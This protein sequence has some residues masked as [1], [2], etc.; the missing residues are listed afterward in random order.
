MRAA[1]VVLM[2]GLGA[3][4]KAPS[5]LSVGSTICL[6]RGARARSFLPTW[7]KSRPSADISTLLRIGPNDCEHRD[8]FCI[9]TNAGPSLRVAGSPTSKW[10]CLS[11][12][13]KGLAPLQV[14]CARPSQK[15]R[16]LNTASTTLGVLR[17]VT[18]R[19]LITWPGLSGSGK[20]NTG[21]G[22]TAPVSTLE[23][24]TGPLA[25]LF[26]T[27]FRAGGFLWMPPGPNAS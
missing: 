23:T 26:G 24:F 14:F 25:E 21:S 18:L 4:E 20:E 12:D 22:M 15:L 17:G 13:P 6:A 2:P 1:Y 27:M 9:A 8:E 10:D 7:R 3:L 5:R 19:V 16:K 11:R